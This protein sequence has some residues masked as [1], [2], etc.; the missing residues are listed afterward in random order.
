MVFRREKS[1]SEMEEEG[2]RLDVEISVMRKKQMLQ[3][4]KQ[5]GGTGFW[6]RFSSDGSQGGINFR[7]VMQW[8]KTH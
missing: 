5:K 2:E 4:L 6:K 1:L 7:S 3:E 8:L